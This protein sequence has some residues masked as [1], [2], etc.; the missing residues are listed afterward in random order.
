M[1]EGKEGEILKFFKFYSSP[2][3]SCEVAANAQGSPR[4]GR[5][6]LIVLEKAIA[7]ALAVLTYCIPVLVDWQSELERGFSVFPGKKQA[8]NQINQES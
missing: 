1:R 3:S 2:W 5:K 8:S 6:G 7:S 4:L